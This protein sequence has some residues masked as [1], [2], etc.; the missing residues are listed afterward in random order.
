MEWLW[1]DT[2][3]QL[4][5]A[6]HPPK[7]VDDYTLEKVRAYGQAIDRARRRREREL[8]QIIRAAHH[9]EPKEFSEFLKD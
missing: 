4:I 2:F 6:H 7:D 9:Y 1:S 5:G 3:Q 8:A